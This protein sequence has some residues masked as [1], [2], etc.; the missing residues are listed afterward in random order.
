MI[1]LIHM[2]LALVSDYSQVLH[3]QQDSCTSMQL[4]LARVQKCTTGV[5]CKYIQLISNRSQA[6]YVLC[7]TSPNIRVIFKISQGTEH[8]SH[9]FANLDV[10]CSYCTLLL[11][12]SFVIHMVKNFRDKN[13]GKL[14][15]ILQGFSLVSIELYMA[16]HSSVCLSVLVRPLDLSLI[17]H[18]AKH[19]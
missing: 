11:W 3:E 19:S 18:M 2:H 9:F 10:S 6:V 1:G 15:A 7:R 5:T 12:H 4:L 16:S 14:Q 8:Y 13:F 17:T